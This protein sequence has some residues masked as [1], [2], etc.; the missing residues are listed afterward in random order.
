L[1]QAATSTATSNKGIRFV[2]AKIPLQGTQAAHYASLQ[3]HGD[4]LR[5]ASLVYSVGAKSCFACVPHVDNQVT[6]A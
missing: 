4:T 5:F 6:R 2:I 1:A 3:A